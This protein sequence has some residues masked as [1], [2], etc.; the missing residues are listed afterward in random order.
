MSDTKIDHRAE[1]ER[2]YQCPVTAES[3]A[4]VLAVDQLRH[5]TLYLA[6]QQARTTDALE[7]ANKIAWKLAG[8]GGPE[9]RMAIERVVN[10]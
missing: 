3:E 10:P 1:A 6:E 9:L 4:V 5:A 2:D 7:L 8:N